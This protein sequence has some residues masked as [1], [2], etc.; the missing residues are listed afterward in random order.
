MR[1]RYY[2]PISSLI[3]V[4]IVSS[5]FTRSTALA[6]TGES[7]ATVRGR[8]VDL[9][10]GEP[11]AKAVVSIRDQHVD[12]VTDEE[13]RF[14]LLNVRPG[15]VELYITTVGYGLSRKRLEVSAGSTVELEL[16]IGQEALKHADKITVAAGPFDPIDPDA[17]TQYGLNNTEIRNL[18]TVLA[19]D[20]LRAVQNLPGVAA[21]QDFYAQFAVRGAGLSHIGVFVDG[22]LVDQPL[23][24]FQD[25][26]DL[27]S[28]SLVNG[29][30]VESM[31]LLSGAFPAKYGDR[32]GAVLDVETREGGRDRIATRI[33]ADFLG[34]AATVE[35]P[36]GES[37]K[38][39]WLVSVRKSYLDYLLNRLGTNGG[40][41]LGYEDVE[42]NLV[43]DLNEHHKV[44][45][46]ALWGGSQATRD[47][48]TSFNEQQGF[49]TKAHGGSA[50]GTVRWN[51]TLSANTLAQTQVFWT[52]DSERD[53]N[54]IGQSLLDSVSNQS[55]FREDFTHQFG[56]SHKLEVGFSDRRLFE[57][58]ASESIWNYA[59]HALSPQLN[60]LANFSESTWQPRGYIQDSHTLLHQRLTIQFGGRWDHFNATGQNVWLPHASAAFQLPAKTRLTAAF[61]DYAQ[62]PTL[63]NLYGEFGTPGLR[64]ERA[65]HEAISLDQF[66]TDKLRLHVELYNRQENDVI[67][68]PQTE[69]RALSNGQFAFPQLGPVLANSLDGYSRGVEISLQRR[70]ANR[71]SGW[72]SYSRGYSKYWQPGGGLNFRGDFDQRNAV[73]AYG[74]YRLTPTV[75]LSASARYGSGLPIP[76]FFSN[77]GSGSGSP[78]DPTA[79][80]GQSA[81]GTTNSGGTQSE[82]PFLVS[83]FRNQMHLPFYERV[84]LRANKVLNRDHFR[85]TLHAEVANILDHKNWRYYD[86][87]IAPN[88]QTSGRIYATRNTTMPVLPTAGFTFEF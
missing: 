84:D 61:G 9:K 59:A 40:L 88:F 81:G 31:S 86:F 76:G 55:G 46:T 64:A 25:Q 11:I 53:H 4:I 14:V 43:Y 68:S 79:I 50:L 5:V 36:L 54:P 29:D 42:G 48:L 6:Q 65:R 27:G 87:V 12:A 44:S 67:Y 10:T 24:S 47:P 8:A 17:A 62:F 2:E 80:P 69:F 22:V 83:P 35:G 38:A 7:L 26:G 57:R 77:P 66:F 41:A 49:F 32:T 19:D 23:H 21:D 75:N 37:K 52:R 56:A 60:P 58:L 20:P 28:L 18:S 85:L 73:T 63:Q 13:G 39:S 72:I 45:M 1:C 51:W 33:S 74:A 30:L 71:L 3:L 70:S 78:G 34:A 15:D 16:L 82:T